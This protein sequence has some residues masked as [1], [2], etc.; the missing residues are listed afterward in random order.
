MDTAGTLISA[1][2]QIE[3]SLEIPGSTPGVVEFFA[4]YHKFSRHVIS[5]FNTPFYS[6]VSIN[7]EMAPCKEC[8]FQLLL[9]PNVWLHCLAHSLELPSSSWQWHC[10]YA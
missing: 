2:E 5:R 4:L 6:N 7:L 8:Y 10:F 3:K 1:F 9:L